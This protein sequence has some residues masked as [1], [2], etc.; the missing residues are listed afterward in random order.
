MSRV[1]SALI[2]VALL[3]AVYVGAYFAML[4]TT[5]D[6]PQTW[7]GPKFRFGGETA[8]AVFSPL[9]WLDYQIRPGYWNARLN[10]INF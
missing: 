5:S 4:D 3:L 6:S 10:L 2:T 9:A 8:R 7:F 1:R